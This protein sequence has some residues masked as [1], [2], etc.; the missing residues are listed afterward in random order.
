LALGTG[1]GIAFSG[2]GAS[3]AGVSGA[4]VA[5]AADVGAVAESFGESA[6]SNLPG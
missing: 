5:E 3:G 4:G 1:S 6:M 2:G